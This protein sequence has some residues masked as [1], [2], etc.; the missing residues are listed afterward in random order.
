MN[1]IFYQHKKLTRLGFILF[2]TGAFFFSV[3]AQTQ[4][5]ENAKAAQFYKRGNDC[6]DTDYECMITNFTKA[7]ELNPKY[8]NAYYNRGWAYQESKSYH[9]AIA[10]YSK[11]IELRPREE[12][13]FYGR[14]SS[15]YYLKD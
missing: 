11:T 6:A 8:A 14:G 2:L 10:D 13:A 15:Y 7:I 5:P 3:A 9:K 12:D 1:K 4:T